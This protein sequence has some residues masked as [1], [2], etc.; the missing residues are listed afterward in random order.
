MQHSR[1]SALY[2][3][4]FLYENKSVWQQVW[5]NR[6][7]PKLCSYKLLCEVQ[8]SRVLFSACC[9]DYFLLHESTLCIHLHTWVCVLV[10]KLSKIAIC[11]AF[12]HW[13]RM[14]SFSSLHRVLYCMSSF[15]SWFILEVLLVA[16]IMP[17]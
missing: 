14:T 9:I 15:L 11:L 10:L 4:P 16:I 13:V 3:H 5:R 2:F 7:R 8:H 17:V 12:L 1:L 6:S